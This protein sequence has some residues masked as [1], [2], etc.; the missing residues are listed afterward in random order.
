MDSYYQSRYI[1][2][3]SR[4]IVW[5]EIVNYLNKFITNKSS[6]VDLGAGYCNFINNFKA[7]KK[8]AVDI[9]PELPKYAAK[10]VE[11]INAPAWNL[12]LIKNESIDVVHASNLLE[13]FT[14]QEIIKTLNEIRRVLKNDGVL[15]LIQPN[16]RYS[17]KKYFDDHT[18]K[19]IFDDVSLKET[20]LNYNF[21][22]IHEMPKFL[23][24][25]MNSRPSFLPIL[26]FMVR[27]YI[28]SPFKP[29][30]GQM[31]IIAKKNE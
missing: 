22:I 31:L 27:M 11:M 20:L 10:D 30:A 8:Y 26:P 16:Y 25:S 4:N 5:K 23:P 9:S 14:D 1:F 19:K 29:F 13:H 2:D 7:S 21:K 18:H 24:F 15:I 3:S 6:V 12:G 17:A 28:G